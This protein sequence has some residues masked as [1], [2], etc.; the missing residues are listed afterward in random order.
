MKNIL[1]LL[2]LVVTL[3]V[4]AQTTLSLTSRGDLSSSIGNARFESDQLGTRA[5]FGLEVATRHKENQ[6]FLFGIEYAIGG[7]DF[8]DE[9]ILFSE[10]DSITGFFESGNISGAHRYDFIALPVGYR[11]YGAEKKWRT[12]GQ[13]SL[14]PMAYLR[15]I[16][17]Q[18]LN[19]ENRRTQSLRDPFIR[20]LHV[21]ISVGG[22][23]ERSFA[24]GWHLALQ[25][26]LRYHLNSISNG[27]LKE[28]LWTAGLQVNIGRQ[29]GNGHK[30]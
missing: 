25:P 7:T 17:S 16:N 12:Y 30:I 24:S 5:S 19:G 13:A 20:D 9:F 4:H 22:G 10:I 28:Y 15:T 26:T 6:A 23:V 14:I 18:R 3:Q 27:P 2:V 1:L 29:L 8:Q 11:W 21:A